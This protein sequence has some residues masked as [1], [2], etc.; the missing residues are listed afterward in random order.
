MS[1]FKDIRE[2]LKRISELLKDLEEDLTDANLEGN[3]LKIIRKLIDLYYIAV[4]YIAGEEELYQLV[5]GDDIKLWIIR[6]LYQSNGMNILQ[7][8]NA[9]KVKRGRASRGVI[10][11]KLK[12]LEE[13][14]IVRME[15]RGRSKVYYLNI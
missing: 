4:D 8:T 12:E 5:E 3:F 15:I 13:K 14:G 1:G 11:R 2:R 9:V 10:S 7:I 6:V